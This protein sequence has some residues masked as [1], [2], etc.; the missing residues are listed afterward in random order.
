VNKRPPTQPTIKITSVDG[1]TQFSTQE[2]QSSISVRV[3]RSTEEVRLD[4]Q[5]ILNL[6][7]DIYLSNS[8]AQDVHAGAWYLG[9]STSVSKR[10]DTVS[11]D[12]TGAWTSGY[13]ISIPANSFIKLPIAFKDAAFSS[14]VIGDFTPRQTP[15]ETFKSLRVTTLKISLSASGTVTTQKF[16]FVTDAGLNGCN[17]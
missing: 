5:G 15:Q 13:G 6:P 16:D 11:A 7:C 14:K 4:Q 1:A 9:F 10:G 12:S 8:S 2:L 17:I 3:E